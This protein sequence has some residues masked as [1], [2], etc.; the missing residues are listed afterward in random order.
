MHSRQWRRA[1][2]GLDATHSIDIPSQRG[3]NIWFRCSAGSGWTTRRNRPE[4]CVSCIRRFFLHDRSGPTSKRRHHREWLTS[5]YSRFSIPQKYDD[6]KTTIRCQTKHQESCESCTAKE[7]HCAFAEKDSNRSRQ[8]RS[9]GCTE[10]T[11]LI[12]R[13]VSSRLPSIESRSPFD[14]EAERPRVA[15][16]SALFAAAFSSAFPG[17]RFAALFPATSSTFLPATLV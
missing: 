5:R 15:R 9:Q 11:N 13:K 4:L 7:N 8:K 2:A 10:E 6:E 14:F 16:L 12:K 3:R 17:T 1:R